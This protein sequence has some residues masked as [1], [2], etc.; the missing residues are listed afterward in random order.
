LPA[1]AEQARI[2]MGV[3]KRLIAIG[4]ATVDATPERTTSE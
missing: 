3:A 2:K 1:Q 4:L